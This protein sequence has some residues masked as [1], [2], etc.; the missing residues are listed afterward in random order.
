MSYGFIIRDSVN[1]VV[2]S[3]ESD[4]GVFVELLVLTGTAGGAKTYNADARYLGRQ[5]KIL[6][7]GAGSHDWAGGVTAGYPSITWSVKTINSGNPAIDTE[8]LVFVA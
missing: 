5:I 8:L 6:Q 3:S 7:V 4:G 1:R 2:M